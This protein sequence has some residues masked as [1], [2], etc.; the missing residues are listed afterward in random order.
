MSTVKYPVEHFYYGQMV[1]DDK[2]ISVPDVLARSPGVT[3][4]LV[5]AALDVV[6]LPAVPVGAARAWAVVRGN[7]A[8]PFLLVQSQVGAH[9]QK[10]RHC[11][12]LPSEVMRAVGG[13]VRALLTYTEAELP[14]FTQGNYQL[15]PL[16]IAQSEPHPVEQQ[17]DDILDLMTVAQNRIEVMERLLGALVQGRQIVIV[18]APPDVEVR[19]RFIEGIMALL[20]PSVRFA[21]TFA[22]HSEPGTELDVQIRFCTGEVGHDETL[23]FRWD[24]ADT[25]GAPPPDDYS[26]FVMSQLRLDTSLVIERTRALT[27]PTGWRMR[28]GDRLAEALAY[29]SYR[30]KVDHALLNSLPVDKDDVSRILRTDPTLTEPLREIYARH[31]LR[32]SLAMNDLEQTEAVAQLIEGSPRL[33]EI[34]LSE[35]SQVGDLGALELVGHWLNSGYPLQ[36][37]VDWELTY[38]RI[39]GALVDEAIRKRDISALT[40]LMTMLQSAGDEIKPVAPKIA[41]GALALATQDPVLAEQVFLFAIAHMNAT[42]LRHLLEMK[43]FIAQLKPQVRQLWAQINGVDRSSEQGLLLR[44]ARL[45][46]TEWEARV[47]T[48]F[49]EL[50]HNAGRADLIDVPTLRGMAQLALSPVGQAHLE[51]LRQLTGNITPAQLTAAGQEVAYELTRIRLI[52]EDYPQVAALL[53]AQSTTFFKGDRQMDYIHMVRTLFSETPIP[54]DR[55]SRALTQLGIHGIRSAPWL[56]AALGALDKRPAS[57]DLTKVAQKAEVMLLEDFILLDVIPPEALVVLLDYYARA[58]DI[59]AA[60]RIA[61]QIPLAAE[62]QKREGVEI[63]AMMYRVMDRDE[64]TR[65]AGLDILRVYVRGAEDQQAR[66]AV[67]YFGRELGATVRAALQATY[68]VTR[69][70]PLGDLTSFARS[71]QVA[72]LLL[73]DCALPYQRRAV[74][75]LTDLQA[76]LSRMSGSYSLAERR[77]MPDRLLDLGRDVVRVYQQHQPNKTR[78]IASLLQGKGDPA[79]ALDILRVIGGYFTR[80]RAVPLTFEDTSRIPLGERSR[81]VFRQEV[82]TTCALMDV[83][84]SA[85]PSGKPPAIS[86][87]YVR[88]EIA[89]QLNL[90]DAPTRNTVERILSQDALRLVQLIELV[91]TSGDAAA[92]DDRQ[93]LAQR[94]EKGRHKPRGVLEFLR[95]ASYH[96][97]TRG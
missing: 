20:P 17:I 60:I 82:E 63:A 70:I 86:A 38:T 4:E 57:P 93:G 1:V 92:L 39:A 32:L 88:D 9:G 46:G 72:T 40:D 10:C 5:Q 34:A 89:S 65:A 12:I 48:R 44:T 69:L 49:A 51:T 13:N 2:P 84:S 64:E 59:A 14:V 3:G 18:G 35:L 74:P 61:E 77:E 95:Y 76:A 50:A 11:V 23:H 83:F 22:L 73:Y 96:I 67:T 45:F 37:R 90:L 25:R 53:I 68:F 42:V 55:V 78:D 36:K 26:R 28:Q 79:T 33:E 31:L 80:G 27:A 62:R 16:Q 41:D 75:E 6:D 66:R 21:V 58:R 30:L 8:V 91:A 94:I 54:A 56:M 87:Q 29:G 47:L 43:P 81:K 19:V 71:V 52:L 15:K 85:L 7:R 24:T 97:S